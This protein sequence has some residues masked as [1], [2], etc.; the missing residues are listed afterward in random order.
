MRKVV[1]TGMGAIT[2]IGNDVATFWSSAVAG[3]N[4]IGPITRF[5]TTDFKAKLAA[6]VK[7]FDPN[8]YMEKAE[9]RKSDLFTQY[10]VAAAVQAVED[11]GILGNVAPERFGV[12]LGSGIGGITTF[13]EEV[14]KLHDKGPRRVSPLFIPTMIANMAAGT[15]AIKFKAQG[16]CVPV[17]TACA[18]GST[19]IGEAYRAVKGGYADAVIAGGAEAA[20]GP[21]GV[22]GFINCM[23]LSS[24]TDP[25][26]ASIPFDKRRNGFVMGEGSGILILEDYEHAK[27]RGARIYAEICGYGSTCDAYHMT[28]PDPEAGGA[29]RAIADAVKESGMEGETKV[30]F[31]AHGTSTPLND[32]S[33]TLA[34]KKAFG[35]N[36]YKILI[37]S[38]KSMTGHM[39]GATGGVEAIASIMALREGIVPPTIG[40]KEPDPDCDL[41]YV[42]LVAR[43]A[44]INLALS[45]NLGFGGHNACLAFKKCED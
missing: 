6:E 43:K 27:A 22:A 44:D 15:V 1:V 18:T 10:G 32:K 21:V 42:P 25:E 45:V 5:D 29:A 33:E 23:A 16:P 13:T 12:Y 37:S 40:L 3:K 34:I 24:S 2:P 35:D 38:T 30:Y 31:N 14:I 28:A 4:G 41:D 17:T 9:L 11:S 39:L 26:A 36:A 20:I 7:G 8:L 19:A